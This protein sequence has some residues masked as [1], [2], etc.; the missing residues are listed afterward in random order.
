MTRS[1]LIGATL[2]VAGT[3]IGAG[4]LALPISTAAIGFWP[5]LALMTA[6]W[7]LSGYCALLVMEVNLKVGSD[8]NLH[9]MTGQ[10]LGPMAQGI[11][12]FAMLAL[13]YAL[14]AAYLTGGAS[15]LSLKLAPWLT[16]PPAVATAI[17]TVL[18]G[19]VVLLGMASVDRLVRVLFG[20]K[21]VALVA[22]LLTL[23]PQAEGA[24]LMVNLAKAAQD[25]GVWVAALPVMITSFGFHVCI[26]PLVRYLDGDVK[27]LR[28]A[29]LVGSALP[30]AC[31][32]LWLLAALGPLSPSEQSALGQGDALAGLVKALSPESGWL[33]QVLTAFADLALL[34]S[35]LGVTLSLFDYLAELCR[36]D[37]TVSGR[38]QTWLLTFLPPLALAIYLPEG[39]VAVLG[40]AALPL[41]VLMVLL[42]VAMAHRLRGQSEGYQ[43]AG[44][45]PALALALVGG[46]TVMGAQLA[47]AM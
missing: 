42:P 44:G 36:R 38:G 45:R 31:Y 37:R 18:V 6:V 12:A 23:L 27:T 1:K 46:L 35:F 25:G 34:T 7:A 39:F 4:M 26:P 28:T 3:S 19:G 15:L 29:L 32:S 10:V 41:V 11:G 8:V 5:A 47:T 17:F 20:L 43:V 16:L 40:F 22:V 24:N 33:G 9:G 14:T 2:I 30:L 13:L 21:M